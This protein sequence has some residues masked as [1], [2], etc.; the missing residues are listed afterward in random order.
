[1]STIRQRLHEAIERQS[2]GRPAPRRAKLN[3]AIAAAFTPV[4]EAA[5]Q[6]EDELKTVPEISMSIEPDSVLLTLK[7]KDL[8]FGF[9]AQEGVFVGSESDTLWMEGGQREE[10]YKWETV[11]ACIEAMIQA[12]ARCVA[13]ARTAEK[14][15]RG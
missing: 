12:S 1:M 2:A 5:L 14:L 13:L 11:D 3:A 7:E 6:I 10:T 8:W 15:R 4:R 9:D